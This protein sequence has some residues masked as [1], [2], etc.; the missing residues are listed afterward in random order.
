MC[1]RRGTEASCTYDTVIRRRGPGKKNLR[2]D[3]GK[4]RRI[5]PTTRS[6]LVRREVFTPSPSTPNVPTTSHQTSSPTIKVE[7]RLPS[8]EGSGYKEKVRKE[9]GLE[10]PP[11]PE[12]PQTSGVSNL[13]DSTLAILPSVSEDDDHVPATGPAAEQTTA[14]PPSDKSTCL[15][16]DDLEFLTAIPPTTGNVTPVE[17]RWYD[18]SDDC[19][20]PEAP[21]SEGDLCE[22][23]LPSTILNEM[24]P[25]NSIGWDFLGDITNLYER[26][27][28]ALE[29]ITPT[30]SMDEGMEV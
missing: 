12:D 28:T 3:S 27:R 7:S 11:T 18:F 19:M 13:S 25:S 17:R 15:C 1:R 2:G 9:V 5:A 4:N 23:S 8:S 21:K 24:L 6:P 26:Q 30:M 10:I 16:S 14:F 22:L 29:G 20:L